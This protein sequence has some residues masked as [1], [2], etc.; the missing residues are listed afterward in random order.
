MPSVTGLRRP[1]APRRSHLPLGV[2]DHLWHEAR[3]RRTLES[4]VGAS[5]RAWGYNDVI[6]PMFEYADTLA[7][8]LNDAADARLYRFLDREG[9]TLVLRP[10]MTTSLARLVGTRLARVE[11]PFRFCYA[12]SVFRHEESSGL[13]YQ[14]EF[15]QL[16]AEL[17]GADS[18]SADA[19]ILA[20]LADALH[21]AQLR[22]FTFVLGHSQYYHALR[23]AL[24]LE[25]EPELQLRRALQRKSETALQRVIHARRLAGAPARALEGLLALCGADT[26]RVLDRAADLCLNGDME[27]AVRNLQAICESLDALDAIEHVVL[28][29]AEIRALDYYTGMTFEALL[30]D[31]TMIAG[32]GGRYDN[33]MGRFGPARPAVGGALQL[34]RLAS[35]KG[36]ATAPD[37]LRP[38]G[39]T[40]L[41]GCTQAPRCLSFV[42]RLR[43]QGI[44]VV[45]DPDPRTDAQLMQYGARTGAR[46][47][48]QWQ[49]ATQAFAI[50]H[51]AFPRVTGSWREAPLEAFLLDAN[52][53]QAA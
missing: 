3:L 16:G 52:G 49:T 31:S 21:A 39:P 28:D 12:G 15:R 14:Q 50:L 8:S 48:A 20:A 18:A 41:L 9:R 29:L 26:R 40:L 6:L 23:T 11:G 5:F 2:R 13:G 27:Q 25:P 24:A 53:A 51:S 44:D 10:D 43:R 33:L 47:T 45:I 19:E 17:I 37:P 34:D 46:I 38:I 35:V 30:P 7:L 1:D 4:Q 42:R 22:E 32:S 36:R